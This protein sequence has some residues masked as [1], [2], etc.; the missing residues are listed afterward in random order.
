MHNLNINSVG[1]LSFELVQNLGLTQYD[2]AFSCI[3]TLNGANTTINF[4]LA[5]FS[6]INTIATGYSSIGTL[7]SGQ[8]LNI[9]A[10]P[11][12]NAGSNQSSLGQPSGANFSWF[13]F[14]RYAISEGGESQYI[15]VGQ[16]FLK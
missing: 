12:Y 7:Q 14:Q 9:V 3:G 8:N 11:C 1:V 13:I 16:I 5:R 2:S 15:R 10:L 6:A 4:T